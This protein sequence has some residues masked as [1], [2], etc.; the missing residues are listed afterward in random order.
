MKQN[1]A[2][3]AA[4]GIIFKLTYILK[5]KTTLKS[6][7]LMSSLQVYGAVDGSKALEQAFY[8]SSRKINKWCIQPNGASNTSMLKYYH[9]PTYSV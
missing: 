4:R 8:S 3:K 1:E 9:I 5:L 2:T 6:T 7:K